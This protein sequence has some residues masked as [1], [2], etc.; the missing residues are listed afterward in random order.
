MRAAG[1]HPAD[2][3]LFKRVF[4]TRIGTKPVYSRAFVGTR[5]RAATATSPGMQSRKS[6]CPF[7]RLIPNSK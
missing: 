3:F 4:V 2:L 7:N 6:A 5:A 1:S